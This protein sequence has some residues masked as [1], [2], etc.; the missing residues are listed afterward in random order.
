MSGLRRLASDRGIRLCC[1]I[2]SARLGVARYRKALNE[3]FNLAIPEWEMGFSVIHPAKGRFDFRPADRVISFAKK[4]GMPVRGGAQL[5]WHWE[6]HLPDWLTKGGF[7]KAELSDILEDHIKRIVGRYRHVSEWVA[8]NEAIDDSAGLRK[9]FWMTGI[10]PEYIELAFRAAHKANPKAVLYYN[11]YSIDDIN[12]K[13]DAVYRLIKRL[14]KDGVPIR[15]VGLQMHRVEWL[16]PSMKGIE[17]N[18]S[19]FQKLG[20][21]VSVTEMDIRIKKPVT[22]KKLRHQGEMYYKIAR[23]ALRSGCNDLGFWGVTDAISW[24][25]WH[26]NGY[27]AAH[28]LDKEYRPKQAYKRLEDA[29]R[30]QA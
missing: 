22:R 5:V 19:R 21:R 13:S 4:S 12:P 3:N 27:D 6:G 9:G 24:I 7:D 15:G 25:R 18:I 8:V 2:N 14:L 11:D 1:C 20:L 28:L 10:G 23:S 29:I 30:E 17:R 16:P 26:F